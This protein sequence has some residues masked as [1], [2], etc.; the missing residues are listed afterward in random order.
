M[1]VLDNLSEEVDK[2]KDKNPQPTWEHLRGDPKW[3]GGDRWKATISLGK[4]PV[5]GKEPQA[6]RNFQAKGITKAREMNAK[7]KRDL[8][9]EAKAEQARRGTVA[10]L[11]DRWVA[12]KSRTWAATTKYAVET[13][14]PLIKRDLGHIRLEDLSPRMLDEW[15]GRLLDDQET[16]RSP[17]TVAHYH[18][19]VRAM[20]RQGLKWGDLSTTPAALA[21]PPARR[22]RS[23][24]HD[25]PSPQVVGALIAAATPDLA[26]AAWLSATLGTRRGEVMALRWADFQGGSVLIQRA[27]VRV[28]G[29]ELTYKPTK[30]GGT[31]SIAL[32]DDTLGWLLDHHM[33][34]LG[35]FAKLDLPFPTDSPVFLNWRTSPPRPREPGWLSHAW[36]DL[37][38]RN[39]VKH[40]LHSLR[41]FTATQLLAAGHSLPD[42]AGALGH[43]GPDVTARVYAHR[44]DGDSRTA[45][46]MSGL[47]PRPKAIPQNT[48]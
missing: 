26:L 40:R 39:G 36:A 32:D 3:L 15:Y 12:H 25:T 10:D 46:T 7:V 22:K 44:I 48:R 34:Q 1:Q 14:V 2:L 16:P 27:L 19:L 30:G 37:C 38:K 33:A 29:G 9:R 28:P 18:A 45:N 17:S 41:H 24:L 42:V 23:D 11:A 5:T 8:R 47:I 20:L 4:D 6:T 31:R 21:S 13:M 43:A 35:H